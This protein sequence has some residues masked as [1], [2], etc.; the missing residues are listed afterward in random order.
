MQ[1]YGLMSKKLWLVKSAR[2]PTLHK[3][4]NSVYMKF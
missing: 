3:V 4:Y 2:V 1:Q